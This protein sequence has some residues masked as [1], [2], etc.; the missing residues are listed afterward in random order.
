M[1]LIFYA[2]WLKTSYVPDEAYIATLAR[3]SETIA[4]GNGTWEVKQNYE[5]LPKYHFQ[6]WLH[7]P[8]YDGKCYGRKRHNVCVLGNF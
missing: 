1:I 7:R 8:Y 5:P 6:F 2:D 3:I 4:L